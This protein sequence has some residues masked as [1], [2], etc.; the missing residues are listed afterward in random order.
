MKQ[1]IE[2]NNIIIEQTFDAPN[3]LNRELQKI[4]AN[5]NPKYTRDPI[6]ACSL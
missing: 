3:L 5:D 6:N 1:Q 4:L 2:F